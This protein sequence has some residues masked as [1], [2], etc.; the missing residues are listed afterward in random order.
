M[1]CLAQVKYEGRLRQS[2][3]LKIEKSDILSKYIAHATIERK[4]SPDVIS[5]RM[6]LEGCKESISTESIYKYVYTSPEAKELGIYKQLAHKRFQKHK[7]GERIRKH[8]IP[9][10]TS[11]HKRPDIANS[12]AELGQFEVDLTFHTGNRG[13]NIGVMAEKLSRKVMLV[14]NRCKKSL[15]V[16]T[17]FMHK[18]QSIPSTLRKTL[19][20]DNGKEFTKHT[21]YN[22]LGFDAFFCDPYQPTQKDLVEKMN[23]MIHRILPKNIDINT[24]TQNT[25]DSVADILNNMP[26]KIFGYQTPNE[27]WNKM[28]HKGIKKERGC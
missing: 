2:D 5:G 28:A 23:S 22:L 7:R 4:W 17:G 8:I 16:T 3:G 26:R 11:I 12:K 24:I 19:T 20:F 21:N 1:P 27:I 15:T 14:L 6:K 25:L 10:R 13:K 18:M 9:N